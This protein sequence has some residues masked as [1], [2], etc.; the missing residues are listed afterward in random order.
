VEWGW[1]ICWYGS[2]RVICQRIL[3]RVL[4][5]LACQQ[6]QVNGL[7][8]K[9]SEQTYYLRDLNH[10]TS[11]LEKLWPLA[12]QAADELGTTPQVLLAQ[13]ALETGWGRYV[14]QLPN[15]GS[16]HNLFNIKADQRWS[17]PKVTVSTLEYADGIAKRQKAAFRSYAS[18][19]DSFRDYVDFIK[20]NPRYQEAIDN[21]GDSYQFAHKLHKA[22]YAT[23]PSY[24]DKWLNILERGVVSAPQSDYL[25]EG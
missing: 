6:L 23:D 20:S 1:L 14:Q 16:S 19:A 2:Y 25:A 3:P 18:Y 24:A 11:L 15:G 21:A 22:G 17:G 9:I 12:E 7:L 4:I 8:L 13:A 10:S 5:Q